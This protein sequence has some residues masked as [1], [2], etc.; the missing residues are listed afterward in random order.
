M[1][2]LKHLFIYFYYLFLYLSPVLECTWISF[3]VF[4]K[5]TIKSLNPNVKIRGGHSMGYSIINPLLN[6]CLRVSIFPVCSFC[7]YCTTMVYSYLYICLPVCLSVSPSIQ[8]MNNVLIYCCLS[9]NKSRRKVGLLRQSRNTS[10]VKTTFHCVG[11]L[12]VLLLP[13]LFPTKNTEWTFFAT[14]F[15]PVFLYSCNRWC[16]KKI[17]PW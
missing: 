1:S 11:L 10:A 12:Y 2:E 16:R 4:C 14:W 6:W 15:M 8:S 9:D 7:F 3:Y 5:M 13:L 17:P